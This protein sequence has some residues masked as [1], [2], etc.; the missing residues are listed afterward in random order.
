MRYLSM[1]ETLAMMDPDMRDL[2]KS[3]AL[4]I[5]LIQKMSLDVYLSTWDLVHR[6]II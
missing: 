6:V 5:K 4:H 2:I 3:V 1:Q